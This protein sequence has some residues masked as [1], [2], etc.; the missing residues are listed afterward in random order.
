MSNYFLILER[1]PKIFSATILKCF[2]SLH[3]TGSHPAQELQGSMTPLKE[4]VM[5]TKSST[6]PHMGY[7]TSVP[8]QKALMQTYGPKPE[9]S[10]SEK[11]VTF[12]DSPNI[13]HL[14]EKSNSLSSIK[15]FKNQNYLCVV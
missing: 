11:N 1:Q 13:A 3:F 10:L 8:N 2:A 15:N 5:I 12:N 7:D 9:W 14:S 6:M 4:G